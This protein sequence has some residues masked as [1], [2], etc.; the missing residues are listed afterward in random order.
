[1]LLSDE[2]EDELLQEDEAVESESESES[3]S[4]IQASDSALT[5]RFTRKAW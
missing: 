5:M 2:D 3:S 4:L 1:L